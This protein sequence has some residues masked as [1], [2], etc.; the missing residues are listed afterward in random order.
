MWVT[1][2]SLLWAAAVVPSTPRVTVQVV[3]PAPPVTSRISD[4]IRIRYCA[5]VGKPAAEATVSEVAL[6]VMAPLSVVLAL[7]LYCSSATASPPPIAWSTALAM[8]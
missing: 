7:L 6:S 2:A 4:S 3:V 8:P 1:T 5:A